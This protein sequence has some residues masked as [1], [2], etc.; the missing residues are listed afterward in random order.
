M[1]ESEAQE[2]PEEVMLGAVVFGHQQ[3]QAVI[4]LIDQLVEEGG[5]PLWDWQPPAK[6]EPLIALVAAVAEQ[7]MRDAYRIRSKQERVAAHQGDFR[8][9][10]RRVRRRRCVAR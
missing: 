1:V 9:G 6:D 3:Q 7:D 10:R 2:L 5:K 4:A 8:E